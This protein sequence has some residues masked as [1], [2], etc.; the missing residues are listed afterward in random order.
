MRAAI[1]SLAGLV[2]LAVSPVLQ[3]ADGDPAQLAMCT[4]CHGQNGISVN[5]MWPNIAGQSQAYLVKSMKDYRDG[6][7]KDCLMVPPVTGMSD[8]D[9]ESLAAYFSG[10]SG[11]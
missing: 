6:V 7:R 2:V 3:A 4:A 5:P 10:L 8:A 9:I 1:T 11:N